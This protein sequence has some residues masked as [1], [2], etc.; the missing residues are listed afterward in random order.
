MK[1]QFTIPAVAAFALVVAIVHADVKTKEKTLMKFG[2]GMMGALMNR[3]VGDA[4]KDGIINT[5]AVKGSRKSSINDSTGQIIDLGEEKIYDLDVKKKEYRVTT[6]AEMRQRIKD[7]QEKAAKQAKDAPP[8]DK[9]LQEAGKQIE[10]EFDVKE[11]GQTK[12][13]AGYNAKE[14]IM[15]VTMHE[16]DRKLEDSGGMVMKSDVWLGPNIAALDEIA[17]FDMKYYKALY[18][19]SIGLDP[20]AMATML[21]MYPSMAKMGARLQTEAQKM[22]GTPL[23]TTTTFESVKSAE[24]MKAGAQPASGGGGGIGGMLASRIAKKGPA[25]ARSTLMTTTLERLSIETSASAED[26]A[27]PTAFKEKK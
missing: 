16:K 5:V 22:Q 1:R 4:A 15:T 19:D 27:V 12:Q 18:G 25:E 8:E 23:L 10:F 17:A 14:V 13:I 2:G 6:F 7:A 21:A 11:T 3:A 9:D 24:Q 26:V 20:Q